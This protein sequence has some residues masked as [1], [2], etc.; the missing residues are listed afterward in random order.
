MKLTYFLSHGNMIYC[1]WVL[2][3]IKNIECQRPTLLY[4]II[5]VYIRVK[6]LT[7]HSRSQMLILNI[8]KT[9]DAFIPKRYLTCTNVLDLYLKKKKL[10]CC[11]SKGYGLLARIH[12]NIYGLFYITSLYRQICKIFNVMYY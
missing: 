12:L 6:E 5:L 9:M 10:S 8:S 1:D 11:E 7:R 2:I 3:G 4:L